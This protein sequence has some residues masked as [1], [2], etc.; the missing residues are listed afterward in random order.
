MVDFGT[1]N[2][3]VY[4]AAIGDVGG[5]D[6]AACFGVLSE[7]ERA[8]AHRFK[9]DLHRH[10]Y[11]RA[12]GMLRHLLARY[13]D[14]PA[15]QIRFETGERGKPFIRGGDLHFNMSHSADTAVYAVSREGHIGVD[16]EM[17]DRRV[18][19][20]DLARHYYTA[21]EQQVLGSLE[22]SGRRALFFHLWTAK[23]AR[24][25]VTGEGLALDPR[26][27]DVE[28][29][30]GRLLGYRRPVQPM[31]RLQQI[32]LGPLSGACTVAGLFTPIALLREFTL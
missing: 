32:E 29:E 11:I 14:M 4:H 26:E 6:L 2:T 17:Y 21:A 5:V 31:A 15:G 9:F 16:V 18:E 12:H 27:I 28:I 25:K 22:G 30:G 20:D 1:E 10:R 13:L 24:M 19:I 8:R 3:H 23:E 7:A